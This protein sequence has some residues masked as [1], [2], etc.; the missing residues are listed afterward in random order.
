MFFFE[1]KFLQ[2][3]LQ[4]QTELETDQGIFS[5]VKNYLS[6]RLEEMPYEKRE[7]LHKTRLYYHEAYG[8]FAEV[9][10]QCKADVH[11]SR[12]IH[13][14]GQLMGFTKNMFDLLP[15][16]NSVEFKFT[17]ANDRFYIIKEDNPDNNE[18]YKVQIVN[19][20]LQLTRVQF[21]EET[22]EEFMLRWARDRYYYMP[23]TRSDVSI[24]KYIFTILI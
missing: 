2:S 18:E 5:N 20:Q 19:A 9:Q 11:K 15:P 10:R 12:N 14:R 13:L 7:F 1:L 8:N 4:T 21:A 23:Y 6:V 17:K 16:G 3:Q 24:K 22:R